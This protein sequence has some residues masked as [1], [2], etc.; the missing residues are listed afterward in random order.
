MSE[1]LLGASNEVFYYGG[2]GNYTF[3]ILYPVIFKEPFNLDVMKAAANNAAKLYPELA[4]RPVI[5]DNIFAA[6]PNDSDVVFYPEDGK[7]RYL[8]TDETGGYMFYFSYSDKELTLHTYHGWSDAAGASTYLRTVFFFYLKGLGIYEPDAELEAVIRTESSDAEIKNHD[9]AFDPY[10]KY[11]NSDA[12]PV[13]VPVCGELFRLPEETF[14]EDVNHNR[15]F[16]VRVST[17]EFIKKT[18]ELKVSFAPL[19]MT[20]FA[21]AIDDAYDMGDKTFISMLPVDLRRFFSSKTVVNFSDGVKV[22][23]TAEDRRKDIADRCQAIK[24]GISSQLNK[25]NFEATMAAKIAAIDKSIEAERIKAAKPVGKYVLPFTAGISYPGKFYLGAQIETMLDS[26]II[27]ALSRTYVITIST[28]GD[29]MSFDITQR[30]EDSSIADSLVKVLRGYGFDANIVIDRYIN[31]DILD[32][33]K[34][35][36]V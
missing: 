4:I 22:V 10:R 26:A 8:G 32:K 12:V 11:T 9:D 15:E 19:I 21:D 6:E 17:S 33:D 31:K 27:Y 34:L 5:K 23:Q 7:P 20:I 29:D 18:K 3:N 1:R 16:R 24:A 25:E 35:K 30:L 13:D 2:K 36:K 14:S 28:F